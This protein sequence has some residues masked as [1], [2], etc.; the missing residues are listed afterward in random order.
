M[1]LLHSP[2]SD[3][4]TGSQDAV[5]SK[6]RKPRAKTR[7]T[8]TAVTATSAWLSKAQADAFGREMDAIRE[9]ILASLGAKDAAYIRR[10]IRIQRG[11]EIGGRALIYAGIVFPPAFLAGAATLGVAKILDNMEVGHNIMHGQWDWMR[12]PKI[13]SSSWEWDTACPADQW[14]HSHNVEHHTWTN[15]VGKDKDVGYG[16]LRMSTQEPWQPR[17]LLNPI[18][19]LL[20]ATLFQWGVAVHDTGIEQ[21]RTPAGLMN[22][23]PETKT[24][25]RG[26]WKKAK[27]QVLKDYVLFP[28][29]AGPFFLPVLAA[30][31]AANLIRNFWT[32][33]I[34][35]CGHFPDGV[36]QFSEESIEGES[37]GQWYLRQL[38]GSANIEGGKLFHVMSGN[39]SFQIEHHLFPDLPSNRYAEIAP[40]VQALCEKYGLPYN[41]A[42]LTRQFGTTIKRVFQMAAPS[43][44]ELKAAFA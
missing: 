1:T 23:K 9:Q 44:Q 32:Y 18:N 42:S 13:H 11:T 15:V 34:I 10:M 5:G 29:L 3:A 31:V 30:N 27:K 26:V 43:R 41:S 7:A 21:V 35:F 24:K 16:I 8:P 40:Q 36:Q 38:L 25:L 14:K 37:R 22:L 17:H 6:I 39:L 28:A 20:L 4:E 19:N 33:M 12:D 2:A